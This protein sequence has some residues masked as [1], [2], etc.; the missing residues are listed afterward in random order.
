M[1]KTD[2]QFV[3]L[4]KALAK[5]GRL[6][7]KLDKKDRRISELEAKVE[8]FEEEEEASTYKDEWRWRHIREWTDKENFGLPV[9]RLELRWRHTKGGHGIICDYFLVYRHFLN[10]IQAI[11]LG[12]TTRHGGIRNEKLP[13]DTPFREGTHIGSDM[14][15]LK[16]RGFVV[17]TD[18]KWRELRLGNDGR[19]VGT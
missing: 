18:G 2:S 9:P 3:E 8:K 10:H 16:L 14:E 1:T 4:E 17:N 7:N 6:I 5:M 13:L 15:E 12:S 19:L 11:P